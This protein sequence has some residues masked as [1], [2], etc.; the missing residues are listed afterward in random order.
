MDLEEIVK[1]AV[2]DHA[3]NKSMNDRHD[4][5]EVE[6]QALE[7]ERDALNLRR[8]GFYVPE[9]Q[10][11]LINWVNAEVDKQTGGSDEH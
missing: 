5:I 11:K 9:W 10:A 4:Q 1:E 6:I 7:D 8:R 2:A 3:V